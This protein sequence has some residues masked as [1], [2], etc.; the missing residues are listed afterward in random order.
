MP[1]GLRCRS[2]LRVVQA[3]TR[4]PFDELT[5][6]LRAV[7]SPATGEAH[8]QVGA[9]AGGGSG[10][11]ALGG[12][13]FGTGTMGS[14]GGGLSGSAALLAAAHGIGKDGSGVAG[15]DPLL[16]MPTAC[17]VMPHTECHSAPLM[18]AP[19][20]GHSRM[21][22]LQQLPLLPAT[23]VRLSAWT[24]VSIDCS[25]DPG[26]FWVQ[27]ILSSALRPNP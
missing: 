25:L 1:D 5:F 20:H 17:H 22:G 19:L 15:S 12:A 6:A 10:G 11:G 2:G 21:A 27:P 14:A 13:T 9:R 8:P 7:S 26:F 24:L 16:S 18:H 23:G 3:L 4:P